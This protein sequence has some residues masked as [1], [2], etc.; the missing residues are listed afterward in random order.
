MDIRPLRKDGLE[1]PATWKDRQYD[2]AATAVLIELFRALAP[3]TRII[4]NDPDIPFARRLAYHD[5]HFHLEM[6]G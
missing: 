6:R 4:F 3:V 2:Q 5:D 1:Q